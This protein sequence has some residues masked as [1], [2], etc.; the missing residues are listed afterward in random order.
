MTAEIRSTQ[1]VVLGAG[2][3]GL[4]AAL[5]VARRTRRLDV[6]VLLVNPSERFIERLRMHQLATGQQLKEYSIPD[7]IAGTGIEFVQGWATTISVDANWLLVE[8][9]DDSPQRVDFDYL[10]YAIGSAA[11]TTTVPG[12]EHHAFTLDSPD[13][14]VRF[15]RRLDSLD[16]YGTVAVCGNGLTGVEAAS[17]IAESHPGLRVVLIGKGEP[18]SM[19]G[20][21]ARN[22]LVSVLDRL[23]IESLSH[24][25]IT[26]VLPDAVEVADHAAIPIDAC[27]WTT[28]FWASPLARDAG[29][30]VD[31]R[32]R[33]VVDDALRSI[34]HPQVLAVG[35]SAAITQPW[36][37][38]HGTCQSG[39]PT[40]IHAADMIARII[41]NK[42]TKRFRFGYIHQPV[43]LGRRD[44]VVQF[45]KPNDAPRRLFLKGRKAARYK[46]TVSSSPPKV[47]RASR[48]VTLPKAFIAPRGGRAT[49]RAAPVTSPAGPG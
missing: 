12:V 16:G 39:V 32:G 15:A 14:C 18:G 2:Y 33:I 48:K 23:G 42:S 5:R 41:R 10:I 45:A 8:R 46:E 6:K 29:L 47:Y 26:K 9:A 11:N 35:D 38:I 21:K 3:T 30:R 24:C 43:S 20:A 17:E 1:V 13:T 49:R 40:A 31:E 37:E 22:Y 34:S 44:G 27:L 19:M 28:G 7:L 36:G 25:E 4:M